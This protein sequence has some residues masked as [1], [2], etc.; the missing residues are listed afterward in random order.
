M[1]LTI[2]NDKSFLLDFLDFRGGLNT[3]D[4]DTIIKDNELSDVSNFNYDKR[5]ALKVRP[6]FA[7]FGNTALG[8]YDVMSVGGYYRVG[9]DVEIIATGST[10]VATVTSSGK[11][12]IKTGLTGDGNM[13]DMHQFMNH[14]YMANGEDETLV[15]DGTNVTDIGYTIPASGVT[16][17]EGDAGVL[18][19]KVYQY[20]VTYYYADGQ[21]NSNAT[22]TS[23][24]PSANK[25]VNLSAIPTGGATVTQRRLY[26]TEGGG[27]TFALLTTINDNTTTVYVDNIADAALGA[28]MDTDNDAPPVFNFIVNHKGRLWGLGDPDNPSRLYYS[29]S[30]Q[31]ESFPSTNYWDVGR[32]DGNIGKGLTVSLGLLVIFKNYSTWIISGDIP[33]G[34]TADMELINANPKIGLAS[35]ATMAHDGN[36][37]IFLSPNRGVQMLSRVIL[38]STET[39]D[40]DPLSD[41]IDTTVEGLAEDYLQY[42]CGE[43]FGNKYHLFVPSGESQTENNIGLILDLRGLEPE[44]EDTIRWTKYTNMIFACCRV[45]YDS[46]GDRLLCGTN[47]TTGFIWDFGS[48][49]SDNGITI[50]AHATTKNHAVGDFASDK[51]MRQLATYGRASEDWAFTIRLFTDSRGTVTQ[52]TYDFSTVSAVAGDDVL[53]DTFAFDKYMWDSNSAYTNVITNFI[54]PKLLTQ[55]KVNLVK[56]KIE[57]VT[58][59]QQFTFYGAVIKGFIGNAYIY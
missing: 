1:A 38:A 55:S 15:Y 40:V 2:N 7:K 19:N 43:V 42:A 20:H 5:G 28:D 29:K 59:N 46:S 11:S 53:W 31:P 35:F 18:E 39:L 36:D 49:V 24:T 25:K 41:K 26:R 56:A 23:I 4:L 47:D 51:T 30:L 32:D 27:S 10:V 17:V 54:K 16:A 13:F 9:E 52:D 34:A 48:G 44:D 37:L 58:A 50:S 45:I 22:P 6:G 14:Y 21:S 57:S 12:N 8:S 33:T 3:R